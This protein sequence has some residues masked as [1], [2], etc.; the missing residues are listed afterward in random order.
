MRIRMRRVE[1]V[2]KL[3]RHQRHYMFSPP[4]INHTEHMTFT[5]IPF[6]QIQAEWA[7]NSLMQIARCSVFVIFWIWNAMACG[8]TSFL[9]TFRWTANYKFQPFECKRNVTRDNVIVFGKQY[10]LESKEC[11]NSLL[12]CVHSTGL[13]LRWCTRAS[14]CVCVFGLNNIR[15]VF[16]R[17]NV[18]HYALLHLRYPII[19]LTPEFHNIHKLHRK[20][21][22]Q[23]EWEREY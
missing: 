1:H 20:I 18:T 6:E 19:I 14:V 13:V 2:S 3:I 17:W 15:C 5:F 23:N 12:C 4:L 7:M 16:D 22:I 21:E 10:S 8:C 11:S 9:I